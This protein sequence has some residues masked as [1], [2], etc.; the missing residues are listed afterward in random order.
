MNCEKAEN[1]LSAYLD[2][3]LDPQLREEIAA[4]LESCAL[5]SEVV[6]EYRRFD[7]LLHDTPRVSPPPELHDRIFGSPEFAAILR[8]QTKSEE[9]PASSLTPVPG[10]SRTRGSP[11]RWSR[12]ALQSAAVLAIIIGSA[13]L[14]KQGFFHSSPVT[15]SRPPTPII[16]GINPNAEPL[17][18]GSRVVYEHDRALWSA[19]EN[20]AGIG[21]Q[22]TPANIT[23]SDIWSASPNGKL[24][25]YVEAGNGRIHVIRSDRQN[26]TLFSSFSLTCPTSGTT[27][28]VHPILSWS[29]DSEH[30]AYL[31][32][33]GS[34]HL[35]NVDG[36]ADQVVLTSDHG[37]ATSLLWSD[38]G[39][40]LAI[41]AVNGP[42]ESIWNYDLASTAV[43]Q[44]SAAPDPSTSAATLRDMFWLPGSDHPTL[45]WTAWQANTGSLT[46]IFSSAA[47]PGSTVQRLTPTNV[48]L[49]AADFTPQQ[50]T[51]TW[52]VGYVDQNGAPRIAIVSG[53]RPGLSTTAAAQLDN[54]ITGI[55]WSP[56]GDIAAIVDSTGQ[57]YLATQNGA[58][59]LMVLGNVSG[60][61]IWSPDGAHLATPLGKSAAGVEIISLDISNGTPNGVH[62]LLPAVPGVT[63]ATMLWSTDSQYIAV[64]GQSGTYLTSSDGVTVKQVDTQAATGP[65]SWSIA[66]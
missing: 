55:Y 63:T 16:G 5:C 64:S 65:F 37:N 27:C 59:L 10:Q 26:D 23:V 44:I 32:V 6:A 29:P 60:T 21:E 14:L 42:S 31:A 33:D 2:D 56:D 25:A 24:V 22:L 19:P 51:G 3:M 15:T 49:T 1:H 13:L 11:L 62:R 4:H 52:L 53:S 45:T 50:G 54:T 17:S 46:G 57:M 20:G 66:G 47:V 36:T 28:M 30:I 12:I 41:V 39:R 38:D 35:V 18:A 40:D 58:S 61:P 48:Q 9:S 34:L 8:D 7:M 43:R